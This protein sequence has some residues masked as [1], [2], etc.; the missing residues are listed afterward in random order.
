M[1]KAAR[2]L[3]KNG[4]KL[5]KS[6]HNWALFGRFSMVQQCPECDFAPINTDFPQDPPKISPKFPFFIFPTHDTLFLRAS[7]PA[8]TFTCSIPKNTHTGLLCLPILPYV[9]FDVRTFGRC[10]SV[11]LLL[12][13]CFL[14]EPGSEHVI[15]LRL[16]LLR[17]FGQKT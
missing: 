11:N 9:K 17:V 3:Y 12:K 6:A 13:K 8:N 10:S 5:Y 2:L 7:C 14:I 1:S 4:Q 16:D 15:L